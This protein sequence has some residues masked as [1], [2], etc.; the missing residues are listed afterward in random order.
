MREALLLAWLSPYVGTL[1]VLL[2]NRYSWRV[3]SAI[4]IL[5]ILVSAL[6]STYAAAEFLSSKEPIHLQYTWVGSLGVTVGVFF[7]GLSTLM[8]LVVSWLC[9]LIA[10]YSYE[11]MRGEVGE[12]RYWLFF[13]FFVGSMMLLVLSD[14][15]V[16]LFVGWEGTGLASYALIG[17]WFTDEEERM[18]GDYGRRA[19]GVPMWSEPSHSGLRAIVFTRLGDVGMV[20]GIATLHTLLG[21]T[22]IPAVAQASWASELFARGVLPAFLWLLFLGA[23]AKSAQFPFHEWLVTAMT[24]PTSVSA[25]IHAA[26]M[27]KAGVYFA[28]RFAPILV[29]AYLALEPVGGSAVVQGF[30]GGLALLGAFTAFMMATMAVVSRELKLVL[31]F[32]TASQLGYMFLGVAAGTLA[33][34]AVGGLYAG[35]SH[36]MSHAV[37]KASLFLAAGAVIHA[38]HSRFIDD[39]GGLSKDMPLT[40]AAFLLAALSLAGVPPF[41]GFWTKDEVIHASIEAGLA[42]PAT[43]AVVTAALT[44][45][46]TARVFSRVFLGKAHHEGHEPG[47]FMVAPYLLLGLAS[48]G[49][50]LAWPYASRGIE[51]ALSHSVGG[52]L[53]L[54]TAE[55]KG[56]G[57]VL[58]ATV[59]LVLVVFAATLYLYAARGVT[60]YQ[61]VKGTVLEKVHAFLYDRWYLNAVYYRVVVGGFRR[62][63]SSA[64]KYV[65]GLLVDGFYHKALPR[66]FQGLVF[67]SSRYVESNWDKAL[68]VHLVDAFRGLWASFRRMQTG[69]APTYLVYLWVG[70]AALILALAIAGWLP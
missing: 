58:E 1:A 41:A 40:A 30:L 63:S 67:I 31:A 64:S 22:L 16:S 7:D 34:G 65:D 27:V 33:A 17:H 25:L 60:P 26:T 69:K 3:K 32:S 2:A 4:S 21:T 56:A 68:H 59:T 66:L 19:L 49:L 12:T 44:A 45:A 13:T 42:L 37:F 10:V 28:L 29:A 47:V 61:D 62:A 20:V 55:A 24:G 57:W 53:S 38:V 15:L 54:H 35:F 36:L 46:Y 43:L 5:S 8:A 50:G 51:E 52:E 11:Y 39:M 6:T 14:N 48:L 23:L 70:L 18:V 9:F